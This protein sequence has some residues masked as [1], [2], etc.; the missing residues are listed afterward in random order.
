MLSPAAAPDMERVYGMEE[1]EMQQSAETTTEETKKTKKKYTAANFFAD[2]MDVLETGLFFVT[3]VLFFFTYITRPVTVDGN[4]MVPTLENADMLLLYGLFY[5][6]KPGDIVVVNNHNSHVL[7]WSG[8]VIEQEMSLNEQIIKR[9]IAVA[10]QEIIVDS[11]SGTVMVDGEV[12]QEDY[13]NALTT[14]NDGAIPFP[15]VIPEGY[16]FVMGDNR[17]RSTDSRHP[18]VGLISVEDIM[19]KTYFRYY[20]FDR[21]GGLY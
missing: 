21:M 16:V 19:G 9:V 17:N 20:P 18:Y 3:L 14:T 10:G 15:T 6:P 11:D 2:V 8:E 1:M 12:L 13:I 7:D 5:E 4:S